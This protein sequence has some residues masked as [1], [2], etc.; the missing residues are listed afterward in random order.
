MEEATGVYKEKGAIDWRLGLVYV[1]GMKFH[2]VMLAWPLLAASVAPSLGSSEDSSPVEPSVLAQQAWQTAAGKYLDDRM[3]L[4]FVKANKLQSGEAKTSC[5]S[6]HTGLPYVMARPALR[7]ALGVSQPTVQE[8]KLLEETLRR[9]ETY[10]SHE[11][12]FK[13]KEDQSRGT[14]AVLNLLVLA[15]EETPENRA[16]L[17]GPMQKAVKE[18]WKTQRADGAWDWV[19]FGLEPYES[20]DS[21]YYGAAVAAVAV[22]SASAYNE[23]AGERGSVGLDKLRR[24]LK[25]NYAGQNLYSKTWMLLAS[26]QMEGLLDR[27]EME[28]L[29][30]DLQRRQ[31]EDGGWSLYKLGPW[32]WSK[33]D[34]PYGPEG[35]PDRA[36][37]SKSDGYATGLIAY[38]MGEAGLAAGAPS[39]RLAQEWLRSNQREWQIAER[40]WNC[41]RSYSLNYDHEHGG[42]NGEPWRRMFM[43]DAATAFAALALLPRDL[44]AEYK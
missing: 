28:A 18:F 39:V 23:G 38:A 24:Y 33:A 29:A 12:L 25:A 44:R 32:T 10:G 7:R 3:D 20:S 14:E 11:L 21:V 34:P 43:S 35:R 22:G 19:D 4:W 42:E 17:S 1:C 26:T 9:V 2:G 8:T 13:D 41:W 37:L 31:N 16:A 27:A 5:V 30:K 40:R 36:L 6:C 15:R